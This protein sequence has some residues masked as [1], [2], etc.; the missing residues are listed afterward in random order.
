MEL[1]AG[2]ALFVI[3]LAIIALIVIATGA[4]IF[5]YKIFE[6]LMR[7]DVTTGLTATA[8]PENQP[9]DQYTPESSDKN[10][11]LNEFIPDFNKP[12]KIVRKEDD[13]LTQEDED[14]ITPLNN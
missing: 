9:E 11:P 1:L 10:L 12:I 8:E 4:F 2:V 7:Y 3:F 13:V 5:L 14:Q 6:K